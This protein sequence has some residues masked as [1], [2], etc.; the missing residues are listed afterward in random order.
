[1]AELRNLANIHEWNLAYNSSSPIRAIAG[2]VLAGQI[3]NHFNHVISSH[4]AQPRLGI[5]FGAYATFL[6]FFGLT[7]LPA[8]SPDFQSIVEYSSSISL[9]LFTDVDDVDTASWPAEED[10]K[11]R[12]LFA[13]GTAS[14]NTPR[15][16]PLFGLGEDEIAWPIFVSEMQKFAVLNDQQWCAACGNTTGICAAYIDSAST[17]SSNSDD[18]KSSTLSAP[19][20]GVIGALVALATILGAEALFMMFGGFRIVKKGA[21]SF[22]KES[23]IAA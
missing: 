11:V 21:I 17:I 3:L 14:E 10:V 9:E 7:N 1:M 16:F 22:S 23:K 15:V 5:Q 20:A 8:A 13:N 2:M 19:V 4:S 18:S 6:S 12:F